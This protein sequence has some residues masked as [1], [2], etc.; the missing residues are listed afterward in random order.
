VNRIDRETSGIVLIAKNAAAARELGKLIGTPAVEKAYWAIVHGHPARDE[1]SIE[2]ALGKDER[3]EVA[4]KDAVRE[5]GAPA[6][7]TVSVVRRF[8]RESAPFSSLIA[9]PET[10]RKH[11]IRIHLA[12][13]GHAIVG[14]KIYGAD[15]RRYLRF[16]TN[17]LTV[18]DRAAL[19]LENHALHARALKF[20]W[21]GRMWHFEVPPDNAFMAFLGPGGW[22]K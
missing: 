8:E 4:I 18:E 20:S 3:S 2:A 13:A 22:A 10:G 7:T 19:M 5:D 12:H 15:D 11:Q 14:D 1:F 9:T 21:R 6:M 17:S 16:V